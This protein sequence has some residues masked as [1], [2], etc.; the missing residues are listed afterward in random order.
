MTA[1]PDLSDRLMIRERPRGSPIGFQS[2]GKLL[3]MHWRMPV[4][5]LRPLIPKELMIDMFDGEAW[6]AIAP[7]TIWN[8]RAA[9][10]PGIP[11]LRSFHEINVRTYVHRDGIPGVWFFSLDANS[12]LAVTAARALF[13]LPYHQANIH[14]V[15]DDRR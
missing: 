10:T 5:L 3:F 7:F 15:P 13:H 14:M 6:A 2:W 8:S 1:A 11:G 4:H 9:R 12:T